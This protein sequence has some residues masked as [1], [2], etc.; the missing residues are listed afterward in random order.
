MINLTYG[1]VVWKSD[2][3]IIGSDGTVKKKS[4]ADR[5]LDQ[6]INPTE[7][8]PKA[9][10]A[11]DSPPNFFGNEMS[12]GL[13]FFHISTDNKSVVQ[14]ITLIKQFPYYIAL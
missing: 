5:F 7:D 9:S 14:K 4:F 11:G 12:S 6:L 3:S 2:G 1:Q 13:Y 10:G 8:W